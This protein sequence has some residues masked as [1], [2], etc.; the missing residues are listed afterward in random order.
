MRGDVGEDRVVPLEV[1]EHGI[2]EDPVAADGLVA[3]G[4]PPRS[5]SRRF[6]ADQPLRLHDRQRA[7]QNLIEQGEDCRV[8]ADAERQRDHRDGGEAGA[9]RQPADP[10][11]N[12][13]ERLLEPHHHPDGTGVFLD[14][15]HV[16][17]P[18]DCRAVG[19]LRRH[20]S[21]DIVLGLARDVVAYLLVEML[22]GSIHDCLSWGVGRR[23]RAMA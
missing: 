21:I 6:E 8:G 15:R 5:R 13:P 19:V 7:Q 4:H 23:M 9:L 1:P 12:V 14:Q 10:E 16:A 17:E 11:V 22:Q 3:G 18:E 20:A 2:A